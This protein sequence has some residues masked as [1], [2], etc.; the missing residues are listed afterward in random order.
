[1]N[2][3]EHTFSFF[4]FFFSFL[5]PKAVCESLCVCVC[6]VKSRAQLHG[7]VSSEVMA[8]SVWCPLV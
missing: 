3:Q 6:A 4:F 8:T 2:R 1:M 7:D 5:S